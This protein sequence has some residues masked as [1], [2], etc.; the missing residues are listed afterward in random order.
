MTPRSPK[1]LA[2]SVHQRLLNT[3]RET[4]RPF[5]ELLQ[6]YAMERFL[7]RLAQSP[8]A[9]SFVLKGALM[10][11]VWRVL[12]ARPSR[13]IDLLGRST[14]QLDPLVA[15]IQEV[16][17]REVEPD[18]LRFEA[19][20]VRGERITEAAVYAG[21]RVRFQG[22]LGTARIPMQLDIGFGDVVVPA[23]TVI[24][25]PTILEFPAP[26]LRGYSRESLIAEKFETM[27]KLGMLNSRMKD[28][29]DLWVL[30][31]QFEFDGQVLATAIQRTFTTRGT[32]IPTQPVIFTQAFAED[33]VKAEQWR[34]FLQTMRLETVPEVWREM[35]EAIGRFVSPIVTAVAAG[36]PFKGI[37]HPPGPWSPLPA[38]RTRRH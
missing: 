5:Q 22:Y 11:T 12:V 6:Y 32:A 28:F 29:F 36:Q 24:T 20:S 35:L 16:C 3:A 26:I 30:S 21:I 1:N 25:Y 37:W 13:D 27:V 15:L 9:E 14:N 2:A 4:G 23:A 34:G 33:R 18:G 38:P 10:L 19:S 7:Y 31:R 17:V 8:Y